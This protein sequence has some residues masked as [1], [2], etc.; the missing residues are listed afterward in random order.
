MVESADNSEDLQRYILQDKQPVICQ[1]EATW[2]A[3][4]NSGDNLLVAQDAAGKYKAI[5]VFLGFNYGNVEKPKFFQTTCL[6]V[7][8]EKRPQY[9]ATWEKAMVR[10]KGAVK[11][12][13]M[14]TEFE[15]EQAAGI[16]RSW[17]FIDC[18]VIP[19][20]LQFVLESETEALRVMPEDQK[21]W[22][23]RGRI[24]VFC[25]D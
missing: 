10:H 20:E 14:L 23:R 5:T 21:H 8:S 9:A 15:A 13:E 6:G 22:K 2:R 11:C 24:I 16:D 18:H 3:F 7:T 25:F 19:G 17:E 12:G 4:M 1:D